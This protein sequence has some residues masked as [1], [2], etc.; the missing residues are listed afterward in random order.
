MSNLEK[1][2]KLGLSEKSLLAIGHK[3]F[4]EPSPIQKLTIPLLLKNEKDIVGQ[5]QTGTGKTAAFGLPIMDQIEENSRKIQVLIM[6]PTRELAVQVAEEMNSFRGGRNIGVLPI[7]GGQSYDQQLR[8]LKKGVEIVVG[9]PGRVIDHI[10][11]GTLVLDDIK[12]AVLD[13]AD[14]ML[15]MGFIEDIELILS[16]TPKE[17]RVLLFSATMPKRILSLAENYMDDFQVVRV[18][19]KQLTVDQTDQIYFEVRASDKFE[20]LCRIIDVEKEF[21][22]LVFCRTKLK[23][24]HV[25]N[26]LIDRGYDAAAL[27]GDISQAQRERILNQFK[28]KRINILVA[29]D[30]AARGIDIDDLTHVLNY[31]IPQNPESYVHRIGRTG[32]AGK[33]GTAITFITPSEYRKLMQIQ[34]VSRS[35]IRKESL[36]KVKELLKLKRARIAEELDEIIVDKSFQENLQL[37]EELLSDYPPQKIIA[38]LLAHAYKNEF[39]ADKYVEIFEPQREKKSKHKDRNSNSPDQSGITRLFIAL[40]KKDE[41]T[42]KKLA[43]MIQNEAMVDA[44]LIRDV[45]LFDNFSFANVPFEEAEAIID[46]F[47][48]KGRDKK[49]LIVEAKGKDQ[50][51][52][53]RSFRTGR[54]SNNKDKRFN[55]SSKKGRSK[56]RY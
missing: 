25:A 54:K 50:I 44:K 9:T 56:K 17:K 40:G 55:R 24:D 22:A 49:P 1:F 2:E 35:E 43:L 53:K 52:S 10:K 51:R 11:R 33:E 8:R 30:V 48:K 41:L 19:T 32:R 3:G 23:V 38:A 7:Y 39:S 36:P 26:A 13:E 16:K 4:E 34:H 37:A 5:A 20:A 28:N 6:A 18:D 29:T 27:H 14:E 46:A 31:S 47:R 21:Y 42:P 15:N 45:Q 12:F